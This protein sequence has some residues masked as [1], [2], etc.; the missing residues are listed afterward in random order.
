[1]TNT[2]MRS[3]RRTGGN[4]TGATGEDRVRRQRVNGGRG[5]SIGAMSGRGLLVQVRLRSPEGGRMVGQRG[6]HHRHRVVN[7]NAT[8]DGSK[9]VSL[10]IGRIPVSQPKKQRAWSVV[11]RGKGGRGGLCTFCFFGKLECWSCWIK[12]KIPWPRAQESQC[13]YYDGTGQELGWYRNGQY[14]SCG[15]TLPDW[16]VSFLFFALVAEIP[17][18]TRVKKETKGQGHRHE[19]KQKRGRDETMDTIGLKVGP[20]RAC[21]SLGSFAQNKSPV[22]A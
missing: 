19:G 11:A 21:L 22:R 14:F 4:G 12:G 3:Y 18:T 5:R 10:S 6:R 15:R 1:M 20:C 8:V 2:R 7:R 17:T 9:Q 16:G 13:Y